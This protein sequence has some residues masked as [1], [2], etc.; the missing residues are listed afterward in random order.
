VQIEFL[1][2]GR[3]RVAM[4]LRVRQPDGSLSPPCPAGIGDI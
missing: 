2:R 1:V 3:G 4:I